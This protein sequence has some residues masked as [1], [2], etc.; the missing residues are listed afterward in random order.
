MNGQA[1][2]ALGSTSRQLQE[3]LVT[4]LP[5]SFHSGKREIREGWGK[6]D[7]GQVFQLSL[8]HR[9]DPS[10]CGTFEGTPLKPRH[11]DRRALFLKFTSCGPLISP[12]ICSALSAQ[13]LQKPISHSHDLHPMLGLDSGV[14]VGRAKATCIKRAEHN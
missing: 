7:G 10:G 14:K 1:N 12:P 11:T 4:D 13:G 5:R 2:F 9:S 8:Q 3:V 6:R